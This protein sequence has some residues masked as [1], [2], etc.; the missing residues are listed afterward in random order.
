MSTAYLIT[1]L[2]KKIPVDENAHYIGVDAG[3]YRILEQNLKIEY[4]IGDFDCLL[5][6]SDAAD[7]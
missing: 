7:E 5:Y 4:A 1:P 3:S 2:S 6:T